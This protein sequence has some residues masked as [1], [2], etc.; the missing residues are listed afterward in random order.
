MSPRP[1][2]KLPTSQWTPEYN[3]PYTL[4]VRV[5]REIPPDVSKTQ[6]SLKGTL[7]HPEPTGAARRVPAGVEMINSE[8]GSESSHL[9]DDSQK[10]EKDI[11]CNQQEQENVL[12]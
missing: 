8:V 1:L 6:K 9:C 7:M 2:L 12:L 10:Q 4:T 11:N 3:K 5:K